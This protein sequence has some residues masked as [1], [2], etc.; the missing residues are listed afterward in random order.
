MHV[1][2]AFLKHTL[3]M[4]TYEKILKPEIWGK[5]TLSFINQ[6]LLLSGVEMKKD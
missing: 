5:I 2:E 1:L 4:I 3:N 6:I